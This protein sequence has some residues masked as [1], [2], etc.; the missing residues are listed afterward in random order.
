MTAD[1]G[2][3]RR[4][5]GRRVRVVLLDG[6]RLDGCELVSAGRGAVKTC[7]LFSGGDDLF[8]AHTDV[9]DLADDETPTPP[10]WATARPGHRRSALPVRSAA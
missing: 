1:L 3:W 8:V 6:S 10:L 2:L 5:E 4:L 7:W 9:T